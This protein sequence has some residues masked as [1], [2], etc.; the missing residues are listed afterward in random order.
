MTEAE[1]MA[2]D[3]LRHSQAIA[4]QKRFFRILS[5]PSRGGETLRSVSAA[6]G[7]P[8]NTI[9]S[10]AGHNG[11]PVVMS[12]ANFLVLVGAFPEFAGVLNPSEELA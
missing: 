1:I 3:T 7:I 8:Y 9:R 5:D 6:C 2:L 4:R 11:E 10:Y 12:Y